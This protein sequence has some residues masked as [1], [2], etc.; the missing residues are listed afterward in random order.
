MSSR[1]LAGINLRVQ[2]VSIEGVRDMGVI[3]H[4]QTTS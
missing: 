2:D 3:T 4:D 1:V